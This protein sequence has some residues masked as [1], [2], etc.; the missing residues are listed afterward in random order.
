MRGSKHFM[1]HTR[2]KA[3][4]VALAVAL[5]LLTGPATPGTVTYEY[6]EHGRLK[7]VIRD[8]ARIDYTLDAAGNRQS[9]GGGGPSVPTNL[10]TQ[11]VGIS[12][13]GNFTVLWNGSGTVHHYTLHEVI[14][15]GPGAGNQADYTINYPTAQKAFSKGPVEKD[16]EY[17]VRACA[18]A[19]QSQCSA[20]SAP[21][22]ISTCAAGGCN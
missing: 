19:D 22:V 16:Y 10:R 15:M 11:P 4:S 2:D 21:V 9:V 6:D 1:R 5:M 12:Y 14:L 20:W 3:S 18:T 8:G 7:A 13:G 17:T